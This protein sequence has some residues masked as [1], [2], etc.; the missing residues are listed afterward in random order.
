M[1]SLTCFSV[2]KKCKSVSCIQTT[3]DLCQEC[4]Y[5][6]YLRISSQNVHISTAQGNMSHLVKHG[7]ST[8]VFWK[9]SSNA[10]SKSSL[11]DFLELVT[12]LVNEACPFK[13]LLLTK[14][15][16]DVKEES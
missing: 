14:S 7:L 5:R 6:V 13:I 1:Y 4:G 10:H 15:K 16:A 8:D 11:S 9:K 12:S 2:K 3:S